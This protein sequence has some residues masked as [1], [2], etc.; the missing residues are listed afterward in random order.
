MVDRRIGHQ[1][2][3]ADLRHHLRLARLGDGQAAGPAFELH[4]RQQGG[5][6]RLGMGPQLE[7]VLGG[8]GRHLRKIATNGSG[9]DQEDRC[10]K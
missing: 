3:V 2:I 5:F 4:A 1:D 10:G 8:I 9:V 6:V 7:A